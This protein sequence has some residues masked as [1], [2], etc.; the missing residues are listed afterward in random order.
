MSV[1]F[2][3]NIDVTDPAVYGEYGKRFYEVFEKY[4]GKVL[5][6]DQDYEVLEV[7]W[8]ADHTVILEFPTKA[9]LKEW[10]ELPAYQELIAMRTSA[11]NG[12][13]VLLQ[14]K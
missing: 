13:V 3:A 12:D 4:K 14:G 6:L 2:I 11:S 5:A 8:T 10:Y 1:Y 7:E 9:D